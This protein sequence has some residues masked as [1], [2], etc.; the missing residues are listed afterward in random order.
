MT[1]ENKTATVTVNAAFLQE[2]KEVDEQLW[3]LL[4]RANS[5]CGTPRQVRHHGRRV[6]EVL[7]E[8]RDHLGMHFALEEA[9]GYCEDPV[10]V[11]PELNAIAGELREEHQT[12]FMLLRDL[13]DEVDDLY[14]QRLLSQNS[15][16][17][18][19]RF[20]VYYTR[21][22]QHEK[23]ENELILQAGDWRIGMGT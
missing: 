3:E 23:R 13:V 16:R 4:H 8:L 18:V 14:R 21:F 11:P 1:V 9:Y 12:L 6:V 19:K 7:S 17:V 22:L 10:H 15:A 20:R 2:I 5:L